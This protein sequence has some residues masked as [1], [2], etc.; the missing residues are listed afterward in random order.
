MYAG[1]LLPGDRYED[2]AAAP[3]E[4]LRRRYLALVDL[5]ADDAEA[6][7]DLDEAVRQLDAGSA[8]EPLDERRYLRAARMLLLQGR[9]AS[10]RDVVRRALAVGAELD[11]SPSAELR[12]LVA[13][14][15][16]DTDDE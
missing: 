10:A 8:I 6:R 2:W 16:G 1:E 9:R 4:R 12:E 13:G 5:L 14:V 15:G 3:R 7:G 11:I